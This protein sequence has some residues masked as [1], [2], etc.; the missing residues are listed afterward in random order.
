MP[1]DFVLNCRN[2]C[3]EYY[4][5]TDNRSA[6]VNKLQ[7][8]LRMSFPKYLG[9]FSKITTNTSLTLLEWY[10]SP[11]AFLNADA[12][13]IIDC[14][15]ST[16]RFGVSYAEEKYHAIMQASKEAGE[17]GHAIVSNERCIR[18]YVSFIRKYD[19]EI[20]SLVDTLHEIIDANGQID[21]V[22]KQIKDK[23]QR[24]V[25]KGLK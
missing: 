14:I 6:Y 2:L 19:E 15:L 12:Q 4:D 7:G 22:F 17:F 3:R 18:L 9:I 8:E 1:T 23:L 20:A 21:M 24:K 10:P 16:S 25:Q 5:L 11:K 13:E